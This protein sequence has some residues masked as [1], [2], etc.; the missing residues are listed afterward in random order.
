[1]MST[2]ARVG[3]LLGCIAT[4][5][6]GGDAGPSDVAPSITSDSFNPA[7]GVTSSGQP[8]TELYWRYSINGGAPVAMPTPSGTISMT[9][10]EVEHRSFAGGT[11]R[12]IVSPSRVSGAISGTARTESLLTFT[13]GPPLA[14]VHEAFT[15][16][17]TLSDGTMTLR[18][19]TQLVSVPEMP[20]IQTLDR[21]DL[22]QLPVGFTDIQTSRSHTTGTRSV[23]G[24]TTQNESVD[25]LSESRSTMTLLEQL[26]SLIVRGTTYQRVVKVQ[27]VNEQ[28]SSASPAVEAETTTYW[29]AAGIGVIKQEGSI[30]TA[31]GRVPMSTELVDTNLGQPAMLAP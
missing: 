24:S 14:F 30:E 16:D 25:I 17:M 19:L 3:L 18:F 4:V 22:D 26:P 21:P 28:T 13:P 8:A 10:D 12:K 2:I 11:K 6:C 31:T 5:G 7:A 29:L 15:Q 1:M 23:T 27:T 20:V 9:F